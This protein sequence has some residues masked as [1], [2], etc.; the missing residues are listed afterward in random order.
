MHKWVTQCKYT[1]HS[2]V[3][4]YVSRIV[5]YTNESVESACYLARCLFKPIC[6]LYSLLKNVATYVRFKF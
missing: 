5:S 2:A 3:G 4:T 1:T 6:G